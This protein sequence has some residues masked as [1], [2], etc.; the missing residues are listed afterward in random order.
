[1]G[2]LTKKVFASSFFLLLSRFVQR[3]LGLVSTL[4]LARILVPD[5]FAIVAISA[6]FLHLFLIFSNT[7]SEYYI[8]HKTEVSESDLN[9]AWTLDLVMRLGLFVVFFAAAPFIAD[10]YE[11]EVL[12]D[13]LRVSATV[14]IFQGLTSPGI[15]MLKRQL[16][17]RNI[18]YLEVV[19]KVISFAVV[20]TIVFFDPS[21]WA[22]IFG[23]VT[24]AIIAFVGSYVICK[25]KPKLSIANIKA[26]WDF[27]KWILSKGF[28]GY[29]RANIDTLIISKMFSSTELGQYHVIKNITVLPATDIVN[30]AV[31]PLLAAFSRFKNKKDELS[32]KFSLSLL[33]VLLLI[34]PIALFVCLYPTQVIKV[35]IGDQWLEASGILSNLSLML[36][37]M[38]I[39]NVVMNCCIALGKVR[40]LFWY[41]VFSLALVALVLLTLSG[42]QIETFAFVRS[43]LEA[44]IVIVLTLYLA[45]IIT[46]NFKSL[47]SMTT[48]TII[49]P[50]GIASYLSNLILPS[51][52]FN[53]FFNLVILT[54]VYFSVYI[55]CLAIPLFAFRHKF[56]EFEALWE[57][58]EKSFA[59]IISKIKKK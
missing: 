52:S 6:I 29:T 41:D 51:L 45:K 58:I 50:L 28:I 57:L 22:I 55:I 14:L 18:F 49:I 19:G 11:N 39:G 36:F 24:A 53:V 38:T 8:C 9:T 25:H 46:I 7:G 10:F 23:D 1:M 59:H 34:S 15:L 26:Q 16:E 40:A 54:I 13:V 56:M 33:V 12:T 17:Y 2:S 21:Y 5:D 30:P 32:Q 4:I 42:Q 27:S 35:L 43:I 3:S 48:L 31:Q 37:A 44:I 20:M 47:F